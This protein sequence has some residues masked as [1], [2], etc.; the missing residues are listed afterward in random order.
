[1]FNKKKC[2]RCAR[3]I[4]KEYDF[5]PYCGTDFRAGKRFQNEK[6]FGLLGKDDF[7]DFPMPSFGMNMP[8]FGNLFLTISGFRSC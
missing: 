3:K 7:S 1:M 4:D 2:L 5:C 8:G 6:D